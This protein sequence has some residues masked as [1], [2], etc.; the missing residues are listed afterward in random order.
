MDLSS[1]LGSL[2]STRIGDFLEFKFDTTR[3]GLLSF[4][5]RYE[6]E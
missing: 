4:K 5:G 2:L 1:S 6:T 3:K